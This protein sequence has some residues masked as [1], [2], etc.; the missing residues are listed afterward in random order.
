MLTFTHLVRILRPGFLVPTM[1]TLLPKSNY[2]HHVLAVP[3]EV[4]NDFQRQYSHERP[5]SITTLLIFYWRGVG[6]GIETRDPSPTKFWRWLL[7][8]AGRFQLNRHS[9][10]A[11]SDF[12]LFFFD[13]RK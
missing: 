9:R 6:L 4:C 11:L 1:W 5:A 2:K 13:R 8:L 10:E 3:V 7:L 12:C